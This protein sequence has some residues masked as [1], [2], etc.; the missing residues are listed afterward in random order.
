MRSYRASVVM[1]KDIDPKNACVVAV[2][3]TAVLTGRKEFYIDCPYSTAVE[4]HLGQHQPMELCLEAWDSINICY[5]YNHIVYIRQ[6][7]L[8]R[9]E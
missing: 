7:N 1:F 6:Y 2:M 4:R 8:K 5:P 3:D 9:N